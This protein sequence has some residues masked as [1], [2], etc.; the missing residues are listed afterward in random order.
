M[1]SMRVFDLKPKRVG[2]V[3]CGTKEDEYTRSRKPEVHIKISNQDYIFIEIAKVVIAEFI[4]FYT[5]MPVN[6]G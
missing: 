1:L 5:W 2:V 3:I 6:T 4:Y